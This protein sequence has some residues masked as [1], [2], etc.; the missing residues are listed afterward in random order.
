M[1][2]SATAAAAP[3]RVVLGTVYKIL[4]HLSRNISFGTEENAS[5]SKFDGD[6][7]ADN[8][9]SDGDDDDNNTKKGGMPLSALAC[10]IE[11]VK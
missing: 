3:D 5:E 8:D 2:L 10:H 4:Q 6:D 11:A 9:V 1:H 7:D